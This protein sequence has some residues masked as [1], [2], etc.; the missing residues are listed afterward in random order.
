MGIVTVA[1]KRCVHAG[2]CREVLKL[3]VAC[4]EVQRDGAGKW[5]L[6]APSQR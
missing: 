4:R 5:A 2:T 3:V 6:A 1:V